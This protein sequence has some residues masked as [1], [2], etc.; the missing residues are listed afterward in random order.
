ME[1]SRYDSVSSTRA[2]ERVTNCCIIAKDNPRLAVKALYT[3]NFAIRFSAMT[4]SMYTDL[5]R[6]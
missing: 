3:A 5:R 2:L 4:C 1:L 6:L